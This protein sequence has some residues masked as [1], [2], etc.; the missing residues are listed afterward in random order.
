MNLPQI[1]EQS[2]EHCKPKTLLNLLFLSHDIHNKIMNIL[3][4]EFELIKLFSRLFHSDIYAG[5]WYLRCVEHKKYEQYKT[6]L[7]FYHNKNAIKEFFNKQT[8]ETSQTIQT[9]QT[10]QT[11]Q[12]TKISKSSD[13]LK[14]Y[15]KLYPFTM[16]IYSDYIYYPEIKDSSD[17]VNDFKKFLPNYYWK[18]SIEVMGIIIAYM[19]DVS[20]DNESLKVILDKNFNVNKKF[21]TNGY[22]ATFLHH[23]IRANNWY[24]TNLI[25]DKKPDVFITDSEDETPFNLYKQHSRMH[26]KNFILEQIEEKFIELEYKQSGDDTWL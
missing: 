2:L 16:N 15:A 22:E 8:L 19:L 23:A 7:D 9:T 20:H 13:L 1:F 24:I 12:T 11:I 5:I 4:K 18:I 25:L 21:Y 26:V 14:I 10:I 17:L 3:K 6:Y